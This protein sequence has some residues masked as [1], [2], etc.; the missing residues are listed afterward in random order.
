[1]VGIIYIKS[2][3]TP[4]IPCYKIKRRHPRVSRHVTG[5]TTAREKKMDDFREINQARRVGE[6]GGGIRG[7]RL[8]SH[9]AD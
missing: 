7:A 8:H 2:A 1:M 9:N 6:G 4:N 5:L 3:P